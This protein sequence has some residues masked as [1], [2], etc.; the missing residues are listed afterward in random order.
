MMESFP[1]WGT[2]VGSTTKTGEYMS[3]KNSSPKKKF[4]VNQN[5]SSESILKNSECQKPLK[6]ES[7]GKKIF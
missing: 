5:H 3:S 7:R 1:S 2:Q 6:N 4:T